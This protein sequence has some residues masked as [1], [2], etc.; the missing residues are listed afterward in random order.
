MGKNKF[1]ILS[2]DGG[3]ARG[4]IP[5]Y[6]LKRIAD[7]FEIDNFYEEFDLIVGTS[8][9]SIIAAGLA[10]G[11]PIEKIHDLYLNEAENIFSIKNG[12]YGGIVLK[13]RYKKDKLVELLKRVF[14][15]K[16]MKDS[17]T[18][19]M[20]PATDLTNGNVYIHKSNYDEK[21]VRDKNTLV[22]KAVLS[23]CSA[24]IYFKPEKVNES[25]LLADGGLWANNPALLA[26]TE[27]ISKLGIDHENINILSLGTGIGKKYYDIDQKS[28]GALNLNMKLIDLVFNL[29]SINNDNICS[30]LL[31]DEQ[32]LRLNYKS[33]NEL[34]LEKL[35]D[36]WSSNA[37]QKF[38]YNSDKIK[39]FFS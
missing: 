14:K 2:I 37:D 20:I 17:K 24:P 21:F 16:K 13:P 18:R 1:K 11:E 4:I 38:T 35:P 32:Y 31:G 12:I 34:P 10:L 26:Y 3:G 39:E 27:G 7:E 36:N 25:Y 28:W 9:G 6:I 23:S 19:L 22:Y 15:D 29:Q 8:T 30:H 5:A 33:K